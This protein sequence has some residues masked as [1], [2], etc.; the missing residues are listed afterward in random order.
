M[1]RI[2]IFILSAPLCFPCLADV[3][4]VYHPYVV[5]LEQEVEFEWVQS[6][7]NLDEHETGM[8]LAYGQ[9]LNE[10]WFV[11]GAVMTARDDQSG[12]DIVAYELEALYTLNE[13]GSGWMDYAL[14]MEVEREVDT[15]IWEAGAVLVAEKEWEATSLAI[16]L[17]LTYEF[18]S[19][20]DNEYDRSARV[21]W[22]YRYRPA[23]EPALEIHLDEYDKAAGPAVTGL[24][25][26]SPGQKI[27]WDLG[28]LFALDEETPDTLIKA[29][30]EY[31]F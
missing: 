31:E 27:R 2:V 28:V 1:R 30:V 25:R 13:R 4:R 21:Q 6:H 12:T 22:R 15:N 17:G 29:G 26:L 18:G 16:N 9:S 19:G 11:E 3:S 10:R 5:P 14:L 24:W 8:S 20:I 23:L 7:D